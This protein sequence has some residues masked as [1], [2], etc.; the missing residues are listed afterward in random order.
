MGEMIVGRNPDRY[1]LDYRGDP[2]RGMIFQAREL[3]G[4]CIAV[5]E[6][7]SIHAIRQFLNDNYMVQSK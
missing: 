5:L 2:V 3:E 6:S 7:K 4:S 1:F